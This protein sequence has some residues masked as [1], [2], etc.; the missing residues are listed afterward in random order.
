MKSKNKKRVI[1][2]VGDQEIMLCKVLLTDLKSGNFE[3]KQPAPAQV[4]QIP[5][6]VP[7]IIDEPLKRSLPS[8]KPP[9][10]GILS[11][12]LLG[13]LCMKFYFEILFHTFFGA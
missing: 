10:K 4:V 1:E 2:K 8:T 7:S 12:S 6:K 5:K 9:A 13:L 11:L 3:P